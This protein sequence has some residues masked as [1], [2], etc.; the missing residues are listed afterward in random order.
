M[1]AKNERILILLL[2]TLNFTH[3]L[4]FMIMMPLGAHLISYFKING[5]FFSHIL[6]SYSISACVASIT[7]SFF[8]DRF[9]RKKVLLFGYAGFLIGTLLCGLAP[10]P[11]FLLVAR[12][13]AGLFGGLIGAQVLSIV[14]DVI[15]FE[16]RATAMGYLM[17]AF[18]LASVIGI[19]FALFLADHFSWHAPFILVAILGALLFPMLLRYIPSVTGHIHARETRPGFKENVQKVLSG[20]KQRNALLFAALLMFGHFLIVPFLTP[21]LEFNVGFERSQIKYVYIVGGLITLFSGPRIGKLADR[22]GKR[23]LFTW[24]GILSLIP[25]LIITN[26]P[27]WHIAIVLSIT[28]IWFMLANGR[29]IASAAIVSN[30]V[31]SEHRG[32]FMSINAAVQQMSSGLASIAAGLIVTVPTEQ[33]VIDY[34]KTGLLSVLVIISAILLSRRLPAD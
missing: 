32:A 34:A 20:V 12:I 23:L 29:N 31:P 2:A 18:S 21:F 16:R 9:D 14:A 17:T 7:A 1:M 28:G 3:I 15:P 13:I 27:H 22:Y 4:D 8:V 5:Q 25:V 11:W 33:P 30:V 6:A 19:P 24:C 26:L 10:S